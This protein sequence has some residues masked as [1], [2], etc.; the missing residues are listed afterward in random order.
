MLRLEVLD[1][2]DATSWRWRLTDGGAFVADHLVGLDPAEWRFEAFTDL[3]RYLRWHAAPDRR[4]AHEAE[5]VAQ[6]G[7]W[8]ADRVLGPI[9]GALA[10]ARR[11]V[12]LEVGAGVLGHLPWELARVDGRTLAEHRV[13]FVVD[14]SPRR[15][16]AKAEVGDKLRMLAVFSLPEDA[17]ALNLR[18]ERHALAR[19]VHDIAKVHHKGVELRVL[20]Y[21][22]T[23]ERLEDALLEQEGWDVVH[24]SGHGLPA[25]LVLEDEA[26]GRDLIT[27]TDLVDLLDLT[28]NQLKLVTLFACESAAVT[29][30]EH[31]HHLGLGPAVRA[32]T[33]PVGSL[34]AVA[35]EV[36]GR[37]D[38]AALAMRYPVTDDFAIAL[39]GS[40]YR[41]V[42]G[43][44]QPVA[45]ALALSLAKA[46]GLASATPTLFGARAADLRLVPPA[47]EPLVFQV[48][49]RKL[50]GFPPQPDRFVGRVG[51][52]TRATTALAP[53]GGRAGV[54]F[55]GMAGVGKT[56]CA[57][58][59]A[60][61]HQDSFGSL[62]WYAAPPEGHAITT[63]LVDFAFALERQLPGLRLAHRVT[64]PDALR[65]ALPALSEA[66]E[67]DRV[68]IVVDNC[69]S[70]LTGDG[71]WRD[72]SWG[73]L[74]GA[75]LG[76]GGLSRVVLT[77]RRRF[78][79]VP[80]A[81]VVEGVH[82]LSLRE[83]VLL[84]REW[85]NLRRLVDS[86]QG[87]AA[88]ALGVVQGHP[89]LLELA[90]GHA[91]DPVALAERLD[92]AD[93]EWRARGVRLEPFLRGEG[94]TP[95]G[96]DYLAVVKGWTL[97]TAAALP[98][99]SRLFFQFL[100]CLE[101]DDRI[102]PVIERC[103]PPALEDAGPAE[104]LV[105]PLVEHALVTVVAE[106]GHHGIHPGVAEAGRR[107]APESFGEV[108]DTVAADFWLKTL[109]HAVVQEAGGRLGGLVRRAALAAT[110]Y[111][112]RLQAWDELDTAVGQALNR[113]SSSA[114]AAA[115]LP[116]LDT[117]VDATLGTELA[118]F[119]GHNRARAVER[120]DPVRCESLYRELLTTAV[121][122]GRFTQASSIASNLIQLL[123][124]R[125]RWVEAR[126]LAEDMS[127]YVARDGL[128]PWTRI[129]SD[130]H[131]LNLL[132]EEG[133][134][135]Q[136]LQAVGR[137][138]EAMAELPVNSGEPEL[139]P[140]WSVRENT[141]SLGALAAGELG[142]WQYALDLNA[143]TLTSQADRDASELER[144]NAAFN[145]YSPLLALGRTAEAQGLLRRCLPVYEANNDIG[146]TGKVLG[147]LAEVEAAL[148]HHDVAAGLG[149]ESLRLQYLAGD[150]A[151]II[152]AHHNLSDC[153][154]LARG[155]E[156]SAWAHAA[157]GAVIAHQAGNG[158]LAITVRSL[159]ALLAVRRWSTDSF[160]TVRDLVERVEGVRF[161]EMVAE[162]ARHTVDGPAALAEVLR[163]VGEAARSLTDGARRFEPI[164][165]ALLAVAR[166]GGE[167]EDAGA[168][169]EVFVS[170]LGERN[171]QL[172]GVLRRLR[173]GEEV[174]SVDG[175]SGFDSVLL[176]YLLDVLAGEV[177]VD[178]DAWRRIV[179]SAQD[180]T[181]NG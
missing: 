94:G 127:D 126:R 75:L 89:K 117:A 27:G 105:R 173:S 130:G 98:P 5:L 39:A 68:L 18:K 6:V 21:G 66:L 23:R 73:L 11:P 180:E 91:G 157:A 8:V 87:L 58:E 17:G 132:Y 70:L 28:S 56:A 60:Y 57:L 118:L 181:G 30:A 129:A 109:R 55:H 168:L 148:D 110:P 141:A 38:C 62:A 48:E 10:A 24:L 1:H 61:T 108:V 161:A 64:S 170:R 46:T 116:V 92:G 153:L 101:D 111:L 106:T 151:A 85:P 13:V 63:S 119:L 175:V 33:A 93:G 86:D 156:A 12:R 102:S 164:A 114:T 25:G 2:R 47:G 172:A 179:V 34:P 152:T 42:L 95:D 80:G 15:P 59:L 32:D 115:L 77:S 37:L 20:Q 67:Q 167:A 9:A 19:L 45:R 49:H 16:V 82:A 122:E 142:R 124:R 137:H 96:E 83:S 7:D 107:S 40:F 136:V 29:A 165:S 3:Y 52:M 99:G 125:G 176:R 43:K 90:E 120:I 140:T 84:A 97:A 72:E 139:S 162:L 100:C 79:D 35:T 174:T 4:A 143:I 135:E 22:A 159:G 138:L 147:A 65:A 36:V 78:V 149:R 178:P 150:T 81:V 158:Y 104:E 41:L 134:Y 145:D 163:I 69:E 131:R 14:R 146:G 144:A 113:D 121:A 51:P 31:L 50:A 26:G 123:N 88:R 169:V 154:V 171:R 177:E 133:H 155:D 160:D 54:L 44:G 71:R 112:L 74:V 128:G 166:G 76:H 103:R 53:G